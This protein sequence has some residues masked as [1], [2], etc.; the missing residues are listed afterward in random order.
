MMYLEDV[1]GKPLG[2]G[3]VIRK[4]ANF[5]G[6]VSK[7]LTNGLDLFPSKKRGALTSKVGR[8]NTTTLHG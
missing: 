2:V 1:V 3:A 4:P 5:T 6:A 7:H 8:Q